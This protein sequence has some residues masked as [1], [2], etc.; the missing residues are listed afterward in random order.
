[1]RKGLNLVEWCEIEDLLV[2]TQSSAII[3][4]LLSLVCSWSRDLEIRVWTQRQESVKDI[5]EGEDASENLGA[6]SLPPPFE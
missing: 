2:S 6:S 3:Y 1:M 5:R 4:L